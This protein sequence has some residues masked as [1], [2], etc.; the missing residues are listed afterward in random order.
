[1]LARVQAKWPDKVSPIRVVDY[2]CDS[3][4]PVVKDDL[5]LFAAGIYLSKAESQYMIGRSADVFRRFLADGGSK[6]P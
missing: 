1:L 5:W 2:F 4:C 6:R 3:E